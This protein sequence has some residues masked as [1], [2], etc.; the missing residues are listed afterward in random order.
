VS[1]LQIEIFKSLFSGRL[2]RYGVETPK[3]PVSV[4]K[5]LNDSV[6]QEHIEGK[7]RVGTYPLRLDST[8]SWCCVDIDQEDRELV[9]MIQAILIEN[10]FYPYVE[11][12]RSRGYH[13]WSF[14]DEPVSAKIVRKVLS[15][16]LA[17]AK[18]VEIFPKQDALSS[19]DGV[20]NY[21]FAPLQGVSVK[22]DR[23]V[24]VDSEFKTYPDQWG[25]LSK[26]HRTKSENILSLAEGII[27]EPK[28]DSSKMSQIP[29]GS[30]DVPKYLIAHNIGFKEKREE[31]RT[32]YGLS[33]C[34]FSEGHTT[35]DNQGDSAIIQDTSGKLGY[36]C[37]HHHCQNKT[38]AD[39]RKKISGDAPLSQ[40][41]KRE[42][43][44]SSALLDADKLL[45]LPIPPREMILAPWLYLQQIVLIYGWRGVG[46]TMFTISC[47]DAITRGEGIGPWRNES[48]LSCLYIDGEMALYDMQERIRIL[49]AGKNTPRRAPLMIYSDAQANLLGLPRA[50]LNNRGW[51][52]DIKNLILDN[53]I[54]LVAF[55]NIASLAPGLDENSKKDWDPIN[56]F[57]IDLRFSGIS[58][59]LLHHEN[60]T[61]GQRG[62]S[63]REDNIDMSIS[64]S[65]PQDYQIEDGCRFI[66]KFKKNR[67]ATKEM[68]LLQDHEFKLMN[69]NG[70]NEW[71]W[72]PVRR[73]N[74][75]EILKMLNEGIAQ[76]EIANSLGITKG[77][78]SK[79]KTKA[80]KDG[81][82]TTKGNLTKEG[83]CFVSSFFDQEDEDEF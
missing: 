32:I 77:F 25:H 45:T 29:D 10:N 47:F 66:V 22:Q 76:N 20:G 61:G 75:I 74:Q 71:A 36:Q 48:S 68:S 70:R 67:I 41:L 27:E 49:A 55:D 1:I 83:L 72:A 38:W 26:I 58:V 59:A 81:Y 79:V 8:V 65:K 52:T 16:V 28:I 39:A 30:L 9:N 82:L 7:T 57:L 3:G 80:T 23:T 63:A 19:Q 12:S 60:R 69:S 15:N 4:K 42:D 14:F 31:T 33:K 34:L 78:V 13:I 53:G 56:Q 18:D 64:L 73:K 46:K 35:K 6:I 50:N 2:D 43:R 17:E 24:F 5:E 11:R 37:F 54:K 51:R 21:V 40:F 44:Y 62:T